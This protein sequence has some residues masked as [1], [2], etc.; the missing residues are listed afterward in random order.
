[1]ATKKSAPRWTDVKA[2]LADF[3]RAAL[4]GLVQDLYA[5]SKENQKFLHARFDLGGN[6]LQP[7][8][9]VI[10]RWICPNVMVRNPDLISVANAKK[11]ISDYKN[12][13]GRPEG[14]AELA[15]FYCEE[16][17]AFLDT[18]GVDDAS[19]FD[20]LVRVYGQALKSAL[21]LPDASRA[22]FLQRLD[23][24]R[25]QGQSI[26]WGVGDDF[27]ALWA[28]AGQEPHT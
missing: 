26:G 12:A 21:A 6:V 4:L 14:M 24:V 19:Y 28:A 2:K 9:E 10:S 15:V 17:L 23:A 11:A 3:D 1:M 18:C 27:D 25:S 13:L 22:P 7:Y 20:A 5:A 8:K 16:V